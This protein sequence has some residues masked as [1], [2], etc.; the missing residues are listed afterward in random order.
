M[1]R[2]PPPCSPHLCP[3]SRRLRESRRAQLCP[4]GLTP[5]ACEERAREVAVSPGAFTWVFPPSLSHGPQ[6]PL[7][8]HTTG[9]GGTR[10]PGLQ[11]VAAS[12]WPTRLRP[13]TAEC[14]EVSAA[15]GAWVL[16][17]ARIFPSRTYP[18]SILIQ[19]YTSAPLNS[20][21]VSFAMTGV[22]RARP[23]GHWLNSAACAKT[24]AG[25]NQ[26]RG[27]LTGEGNCVL[28]AVVVGFGF[29]NVIFPTCKCCTLK[30]KSTIKCSQLWFR[31]SAFSL[32][33]KTFTKY[34][35]FKNLYFPLL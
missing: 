7:G 6:E 9:L 29:L 26:E 20:R 11:P 16:A 33:S 13:L 22:E 30:K 4:E 28:S 5:A 27:I 1:R 18:K 12:S 14:G 19:S 23:E 21:R 17:H 32:S 2:W 35:H 3:P 31:C 24:E 15:A 10:R 25:L 34:S 8:L